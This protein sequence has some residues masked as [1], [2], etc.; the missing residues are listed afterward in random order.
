M[1]SF[2]SLFLLLLLL[3]SLGSPQ[4][5]AL[6]WRARVKSELFPFSYYAN[7]GPCGV[8]SIPAPEI[9]SPGLDVMPFRRRNL[10]PSGRPWK[11][12]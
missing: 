12:R 11:N 4:S 3:P 2:V 6:T 9:N 10:D 7:L 5:H 8:K 1:L